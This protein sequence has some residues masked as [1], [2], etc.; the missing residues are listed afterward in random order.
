V[1]SHHGRHD[2][3]HGADADQRRVIGGGASRSVNSDW[4]RLRRHLL[5]CGRLRRVDLDLD[6]AVLGAVVGI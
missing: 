5:G 6:A 1:T 2:E 4:A 3:R